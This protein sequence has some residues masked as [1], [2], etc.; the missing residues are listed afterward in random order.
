MNVFRLF[1]MITGF[2]FMGGRFANMASIKMIVDAFCV[3]GT[4]LGILGM[5]I[6]SWSQPLDRS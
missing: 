4:A 6:L 5:L 1:L 2:T 3:Q